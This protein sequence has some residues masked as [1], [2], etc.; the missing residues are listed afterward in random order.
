MDIHTLLKASGNST[1]FLHSSTALQCPRKGREQVRLLGRKARL[2]T[3]PWS[4]RA[5]AMLY[6]RSWHE[7]RV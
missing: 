3:P 5:Q 7:L 1:M 4:V 2:L 6:L